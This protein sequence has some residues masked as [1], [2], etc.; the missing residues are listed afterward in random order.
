M[1]LTD[2]HDVPPKFSLESLWGLRLKPALGVRSW[3]LPFKLNSG[4]NPAPCFVSLPVE[5]CRSQ[6]VATVPT[7]LPRRQWA[8][9]TSP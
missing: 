7:A 6:A 1:S 9:I 5:T 3:D 8:K 4:L 2:A